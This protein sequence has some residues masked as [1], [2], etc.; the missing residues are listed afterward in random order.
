M[1][2][3]LQWLRW[4]CMQRKGDCSGLTAHFIRAPIWVDPGSLCLRLVW[5]WGDLKPVA[6]CGT[7]ARRANSIAHWRPLKQQQPCTSS[8]STVGFGT[9][10]PTATWFL[11]VYLH[12]CH[13]HKFHRQ[14]ET[15]IDIKSFQVICH[16]H[17][18]MCTQL[19]MSAIIT[20]STSNG[21]NTWWDTINFYC[22][23]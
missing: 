19:F 20:E 8:G 15:T 10:R 7:R 3:R 16:P 18:Y 4:I 23:E 2:V 5:C 13:H 22:L 1:C 11:F 12:V 21:K 17:V 6:N 9:K 14:Q